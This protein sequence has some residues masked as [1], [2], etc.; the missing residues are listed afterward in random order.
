MLYACRFTHLHDVI[1]RRKLRL[2]SERHL[3]NYNARAANI[4]VEQ[5]PCRTQLSASENVK[6]RSDDNVACGVCLTLRERVNKQRIRFLERKHLSR[7]AAKFCPTPKCACNGVVSYV[8]NASPASLTACLC[9]T[10]VRERCIVG[11]S[12]GAICYD[13]DSIGKFQLSPF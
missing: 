9:P 4:D 12:W 2:F 7:G 8:P 10:A 6:T 11:K 5:V 3:L 13:S 1:G